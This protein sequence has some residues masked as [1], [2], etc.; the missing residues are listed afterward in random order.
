PLDQFTDRHAADK[1]RTFHDLRTALTLDPNTCNLVSIPQDVQGFGI[2]TNIASAVADD[3]GHTFPHQ[4][5]PLPRIVEA[6]NKG[7]DDRRVVVLV[8][9][10][11]G[12]DSFKQRQPLDAL[13]GPFRGDLRTGYTPDLLGIALEENAVETVAETV[14]NPLFDICFRF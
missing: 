3:I 10:E 11:R 5:R 7:L 9:Q 13:S 1:M 8:F 12:L 14:R 6:I 4:T 2:E